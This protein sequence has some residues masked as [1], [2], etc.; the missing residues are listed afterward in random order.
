V[1]AFI[2]TCVCMYL[3]VPACMIHHDVCIC[4]CMY[5]YVSVFICMY[6][7]VLAYMCMYAYLCGPG[8]RAW[9]EGLARGPMIY[10][11]RAYSAPARSAV[12]LPGRRVMIKLR[13]VVPLGP[14]TRRRLRAQPFC[15][16]TWN[17]H[18]TQGTTAAALPLSVTRRPGIARGSRD[19]HC[20]AGRAPR[21]P[22]G[23]PTATGGRAAARCGISHSL[24][25]LRLNPSGTPTDMV[26][27][28]SRRETG[29]PTAWPAGRRA[30]PPEY[31]LPQGAGLLRC[32][33]SAIR[34]GI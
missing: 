13:V 32:A 14:T 31:P 29:T 2:R 19:T 27:R 21:G 11:T 26:G 33:R 16:V 7:Y 30:A 17:P 18:P 9:H 10:G 34:Y 28:A 1:L 24:W 5:M 15:V 20:L 23:A 25:N 12:G 4:T 8:T 3:S 22:A 6:M